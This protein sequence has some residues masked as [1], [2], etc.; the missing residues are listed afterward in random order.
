QRKDVEDIHINSAFTV[1][2]IMGCT[3]CGGCWLFS[4]LIEKRMGEPHLG[5]VLR[6][7]SFSL[8]GM[9]FGSVVVAMQR[10]RL[11]FRAL[12]LRSLLGRAGSAV[13]AI[14][15]AFIGAGVWSL[16]VQQV[17]LVCLGT[18]TLW[19][20]TS[21]RPHF[22]VSWKATNELW[23]F[24]WKTTMHNVLNVAVPRSFMVLLGGYLGTESVGLLSLA[25]RGLDM[26]RDLLAS[27]LSQ[28]ALPLFARMRDDRPALYSAYGRSVQLTALVTYP[29]FVGMAVSSEEVISI[30]FGKQWIA[31][32][33]Y[34]T[35]VALLTLPFY[36]RLFSPAV[37]VVAGQPLAP[38]Y[39][40]AVELAYVVGGMLLIGRGSLALALGVWASRVLFSVPVDA[41]LVKRYSG[42]DYRHQM[43]G[44]L[45]PA[46]AAA[47]MA[48][49]VLLVKNLLL[50]SI[51]ERLRIVPIGIVGLA[52][53]VSLLLVLDRELVK[54]FIGFVGQSLE[55][56]RSRS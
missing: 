56:R 46:L 49:V 50:Q 52:T 6:W 25:F 18:L 40:L 42:M 17:L 36:L 24:G 32:T 1:S 54:Q 21:E 14:S 41:W 13:V 39:Q 15:C 7:M 12:A 2:V 26:L 31:A 4:D 27:A 22:Q 45:T 28:V 19:I 37:L 55:A 10:R 29:I 16:V 44:A 51:S 8:V 23:G 53:Y 34:F 43:R 30:V 48:C 47:G 38:V 35:V 20:L 9:G 5:E 11:E 33:P 3:F